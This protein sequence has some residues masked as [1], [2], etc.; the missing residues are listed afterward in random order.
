MHFAFMYYKHFLFITGEGLTFLF[1]E[2]E[3]RKHWVICP[4]LQV[5]QWQGQNQVP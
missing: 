5:N 4:G 2:T 1:K 3:Q